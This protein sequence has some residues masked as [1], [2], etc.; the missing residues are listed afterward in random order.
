MIASY[1]SRSTISM[2]VKLICTRRCYYIG[3][4]KHDYSG[5]HYQNEPAG[6]KAGYVPEQ[7]NHLKSEPC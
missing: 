1:S 6:H 2:E 4:G 3:L 5:L 7:R